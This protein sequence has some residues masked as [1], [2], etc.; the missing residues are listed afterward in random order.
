[1]RQGNQNDRHPRTSSPDQLLTYSEAAAR[2]GI[3]ARDV[4]RLV[5]TEQLGYVLDARGRR[6][7]PASTLAAPQGRLA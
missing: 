3:G 5:R 2:I 1:M 6:R 4:A 7:I